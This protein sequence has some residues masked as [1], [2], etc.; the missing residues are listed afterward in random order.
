FSLKYGCPVKALDASVREQLLRYRWPGNIR[1]LQNVFEAM[2]ALSDGDCIDSALL[3]PHIAAL[4]EHLAMAEPESRPPLTSG[5]LEEME[6]AA[7]DA[8]V[9]GAGGNLSLAARNLGISRSTL[10]VK[11]AAIRGKPEA[12]TTAPR[13]L[14]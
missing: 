4:P 8:A 12:A 14:Q 13:K 9:A 1:E 7:I 2:F 11:L 10:Y 5:R 3:P 6:R